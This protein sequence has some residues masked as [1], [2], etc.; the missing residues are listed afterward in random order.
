[1]SLICNSKKHP[2]QAFR[3]PRA[4][5]LHIF[6][7]GDDAAFEV[8]FDVVISGDDLFH[9]LLHLISRFFARDPTPVCK[10]K[11]GEIS[12]APPQF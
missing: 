9:Q 11:V 8:Y 6:V 5:V 3:L 12:P 4:F 10:R 7:A 1:M 2:R